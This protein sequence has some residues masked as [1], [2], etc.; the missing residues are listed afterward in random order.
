MTNL[1]PKD[2]VSKF[3]A[4]I[5]S[6]PGYG[7]FFKYQCVP[8]P[9]GVCVIIRSFEYDHDKDWT[10]QTFEGW[11]DVGL[12]LDWRDRRVFK[13]QMDFAFRCDRGTVTC[14]GYV[15]RTDRFGRIPPKYRT[16]RAKLT[17]FT[18]AIAEANTLPVPDLVSYVDDQI[19]ALYGPT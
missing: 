10:A 5:L 18:E 12:G 13:N 7:G 8:M 9:N 4:K 11:L 19:K 14:H 3:V 2:E 6:T 17:R 16:T 15:S 1:N